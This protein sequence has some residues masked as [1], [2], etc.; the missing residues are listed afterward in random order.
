M[1]LAIALLGT[2]N[3]SDTDAQTYTRVVTP[4]DNSLLVACAVG[5]NGSSYGGPSVSDSGGLTWTQR[6]MLGI[7][8][9]ATRISI[10]TAPVTTSPGSDTITW[11]HGTTILGSSRAV[12]SVTGHNVSAPFVGSAVTTSATSTGPNAGT[13]AS[14]TNASNG[15]LLIVG[16]HRATADATAEA[17]WTEL[18]DVAGATPAEGLAVYSKIASG[19]TTPTATLGSSV[20]WG[21]IYLEVA[22]GGLVL[23]ASGSQLTAQDGTPTY[24]GAFNAFRGLVLKWP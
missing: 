9:N 14:L 17:G 4:V 13:V 12:L 3:A 16:H 19:D 8:G 18:C 23:S 2:A 1:S 7:N 24:A 5:R 15:Q 11:D 21:T 6:V 10:H 20:I 22:D